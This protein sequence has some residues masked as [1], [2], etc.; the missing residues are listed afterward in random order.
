MT[1][2]RKK[3][4]CTE[5][6]VISLGALLAAVVL[7]AVLMSGCGPSDDKRRRPPTPLAPPSQ[8]VLDAM[9]ND[10]AEWGEG[11]WHNWD[12]TYHDGMVELR[13]AADPAANETALNG[14]CDI[15]RDIAKEH[16]PGYTFVGNIAVLGEIKKKCY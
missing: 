10:L 14:Y 12:A 15:L 3:L 4:S 2:R 13:V 11:R 5:I 7:A 1:Q 16:A 6:V 8:S 9:E